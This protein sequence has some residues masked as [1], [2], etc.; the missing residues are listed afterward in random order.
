M[1]L[2]PTQP[3]LQVPETCASAYSATPANDI[4]NFSQRW[5]DLNL[6]R[7][8][9]RHSRLLLRLDIISYQ[10]VFVKGIL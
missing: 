4:I 8:P 5:R 3:K 7:M 10:G 2:E 6:A 1:G 9:F